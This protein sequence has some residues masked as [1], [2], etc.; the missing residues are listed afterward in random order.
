MRIGVDA[1]SWFN[2]RGYGRFTREL[3]TAMVTG[4]PEHEFVC[5][6]DARD[7]G[8][9]G[10]KQENVTA[11]G[12]EL[13]QRPAE[14]ASASSNR[15]VRDML[16]M[17]RAVRREGVE[18]LFYPTVYSY[19]P[20]PLGQRAVVAVHDT[21]AER[22]PELTLPS[23]RARRFWRWKVRAALWQ[24]RLILTVSEFSAA[25]IERVLRV[26]RERIRLTHEAP[27]AAYAPG[28]SADE[29]SAARLQVGLPADGR[30]LT[31]VGGFNPHKNVESLVMAHAEVAA[32]VDD[33]PR[34]LL[35]GSVDK[36]VFHSGVESIRAAIRDAGT[37]E[38]VTWAGFV[39]DHE[40]RH[41]H[42]G[43]LALVLP[44]RCEGFGLPAAEAAACETPVIA[45]TE[46][47]LPALFEGGG[48]FV[49][50]DDQRGLVDALRVVCCDED[51]RRA[52]GARAG[53]RARQLT[54]PRAAELALDAI[55]E[56]AR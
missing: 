16:R 18:V 17:S 26:P 4:A 33:P 44:S 23:A 10:L 2:E 34:L 14:A 36:D 27:S 21:I 35:V 43:S 22:F 6:V 40:L 30:Y 56:A 45:T 28:S 25:D 49:D 48:L 41:L 38:L 11:R 7:V 53:E 29:I 31:Y 9:L 8:R 50:P 42:A 54:W 3:L 37:E 24:A 20:A 13:G 52:L 55:L 1:T 51:R 39:P 12:V 32:A 5:F 46:S 19:F 47:P 15:T